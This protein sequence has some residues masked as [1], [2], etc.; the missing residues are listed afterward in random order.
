MPK[1]SHG[2]PLMSE[3]VRAA[4]VEAS[5]REA[6][7][8]P[9]SYAEIEEACGEAESFPGEAEFAKDVLR[10]TKHRLA[11]CVRAPHMPVGA[12]RE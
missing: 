9:D 11:A 10:E 7:S 6:A 3:A 5:V 8:D 2:V 4:F 12:P 1:S